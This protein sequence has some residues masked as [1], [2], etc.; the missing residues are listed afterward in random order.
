[1]PK[2][3]KVWVEIEEYDEETGA[4]EDMDAPGA[5][6]RT[7]PTYERAYEIAE[8]ITAQWA[9]QGSYHGKSTLRQ[10]DG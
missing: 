3:Y 5:A 10:H 7:C 9:E 2:V 6:L 4:S 1:M 8:Q